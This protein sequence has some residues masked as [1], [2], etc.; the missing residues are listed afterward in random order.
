MT[1]RMRGRGGGSGFKGGRG[2]H[3]HHRIERR[4]VV[5]TYRP[6]TF[7]RRGITAARSDPYI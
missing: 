7:V 3:Q 1:R 5:C 6:P 4:L 2:E